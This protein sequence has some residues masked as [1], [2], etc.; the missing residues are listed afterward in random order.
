MRVKKG[1]LCAFELVTL[2][3]H[4]AEHVGERSTVDRAVRWHIGQVAAATRLGKVREVTAASGSTYKMD[5]KHFHVGRVLVI[6]A[7]RVN[8]PRMLMDAEGL[9]WGTLEEC[10]TFT[11]G[12][13]RVV[14][15]PDEGLRLL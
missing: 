12:Y 2:D 3:V 5:G 10:E 15:P 6:P 13:L 1:T 7:D 11:A 14:E 8:A 4:L 9:T